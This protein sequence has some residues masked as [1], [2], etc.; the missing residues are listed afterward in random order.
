MYLFLFLKVFIYYNLFVRD[1]M[2]KIVVH[3]ALERFVTGVLS[4]VT[5]QFVTSCKLPA[6]ILPRA[7]V[8]LLAGVRPQVSL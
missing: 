2:R 4:N 1:P 3:F 6:A 5:G 7:D 8:R